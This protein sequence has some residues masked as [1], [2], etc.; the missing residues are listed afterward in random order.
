MQANRLHLC[1]RD[2]VKPT[3]DLELTRKKP[4]V[5]HQ[6]DWQSL[7]EINFL[8]YNR[9]A[10]GLNA[11]SS[12]MSLA[13]MSDG[14]GQSAEWWYQRAK[15][16]VDGVLN[17][18]MSLSWL[19]QFKSGSSLPEKAIQPFHLQTLLDW[20]SLHLQLVPPLTAEENTLLLANQHSIQEALLLLHS[21][22]SSQGSGVAIGLHPFVDGAHFRVRFARL[23]PTRAHHSVDS[24]INEQG[25]HWRQQTIAFELGLAR[26]FLQM[27][28]IELHLVDNGLLGEFSFR[29]YKPGKVPRP[30]S[31]S[32]SGRG[33][34][35]KV[36]YAAGATVRSQR[37]DLPLIANEGATMMVSSEMI[38]SGWHPPAA[39]LKAD[40]RLLPKSKTKAAPD[41]VPLQP[42]RP[43][44]WY[45][46]ASQQPQ[47]AP[48]KTSPI[49]ISLELPEP[50]MP[51]LLRELERARETENLKRL[52]VQD[53]ED[54]APETPNDDSL[55]PPG[56]PHEKEQPR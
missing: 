1:F 13:E 40:P 56:S 49:I 2:P 12:A 31:Q 51:R 29:L 33:Q 46:P 50:P 16:K 39:H 21:V 5:R 30:D 7:S 55:T 52:E 47:P 38:P 42:L 19:I 8:L 37:P 20:I 34:R 6:P 27:N 24:F 22:A 26:D 43:G 17:L 48:T 3:G 25:N 54:R 15:A 36:A 14:T 18:V 35:E 4:T 10:D 53:V 45:Q 32:T 44:S 9:M 41:T 11:A 23:R 28:Q